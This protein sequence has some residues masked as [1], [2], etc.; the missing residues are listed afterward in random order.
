MWVYKMKKYDYFFIGEL[1]PPY[2]GV[3]VKDNLVFQSAYANHNGYMLDLVECKRKPM[4]VPAIFIRMITGMVKSKYTVIGVGTNRRLRILLF[5]GRL[6]GRKKG[7][8]KMIVHIMGGDFH[9]WLACNPRMIALLKGVKGVW[10]ESNEMVER[11]HKMGID[12]AGF[13]PNC[14]TDDNE[15][16]PKQNNA[17]SPL[18]LVFFSRICKEKGILYVIEAI[19]KL[20]NLESNVTFDFYGE[21]SIDI[22]EIFDRLVAENKNVMFHG[23]FDSINNDVYQELNQYDVM[24]LPTFW[25]GEGVPGALIESK[26]SGIT[27]IV[28]DWKFNKEI[29]LEDEGIVI[30]GNIT[31]SLVDAILKLCNDRDLLMNL[32]KGAFRSKERYCINNYIELIL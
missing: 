30:D 25:R 24:L 11:L 23:V 7:L 18:R 9:N 27:A 16:L 8:A 17:D 29:V 13:F 20:K 14:R 1:P 22:K 26:M 31:D 19:E 6:I 28:T 15:Q 3:A 5:I 12:N 32:K 4:K 21:L 10:V 2:G